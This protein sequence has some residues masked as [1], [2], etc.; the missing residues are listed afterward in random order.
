MSNYLFYHN[1]TG[2]IEGFLTNANNKYAL[3]NRQ[4][5]FQSILEANDVHFYTKQRFYVVEG[6][7]VE[8]PPE[9]AIQKTGVVNSSITLTNVNVGSEITLTDAFAFESV[10]SFDPNDPIIFTDA[11]N[12]TLSV[13]QPFPHHNITQEI[14][15]TNA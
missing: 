15:I 1:E 10:F 8:R 9:P 2:C 12:Y 11:G 6:E 5:E 3:L 7:L 13:K 4:H 14:E